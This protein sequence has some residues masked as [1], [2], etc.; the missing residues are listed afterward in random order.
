LSGGLGVAK[1]INWGGAASTGYT[2]TQ[3]GTAT[4]TASGNYKLLGKLMWLEVQFQATSTGT[5]VLSMPS[6]LTGPTGVLNQF[7]AGF[8]NSNGNFIF[9]FTTGNGGTI[10][11]K[12]P[13]FT[14]PAA[15]GTR[16]IASGV[17]YLN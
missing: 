12:T 15:N 4:G 8:N 1:D 11:F 3:S 6:G 13:T 5:V 2:P 10:T 9:G 17:I 14:D 16:L 7:L